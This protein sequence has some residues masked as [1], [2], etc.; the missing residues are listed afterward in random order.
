MM[1]NSQS[2]ETLDALAALVASARK[3]RGLP[4]WDIQGIRAGLIQAAKRT[5]PITL[6]KLAHAAITCAEDAESK[7][8]IR[9]AHDGKHWQA[10]E[11]PQQGSHIT[12]AS[13]TDCDICSRRREICDLDDSHEYVQ[14]NRRGEKAT[15]E[16]IQEIKKQIGARA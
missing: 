7:T 15:P 11:P 4:Q 12:Y 9:I 8:P 13:P 16:Q 5:E 6:A 2:T 10:T 3:D 1:I 14:R